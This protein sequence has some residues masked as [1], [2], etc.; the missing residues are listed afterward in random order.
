MKKKSE[1]ERKKEVEKISR[2]IHPHDDEPD[3]T[4]YMGNYNFPQMLFAFCLGFATMF[5][6]AVDEINDFKGC[7][8]PSYFQETPK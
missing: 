8:L 4:A 5:I 7:P 6:L 3:P 1:E 2:M